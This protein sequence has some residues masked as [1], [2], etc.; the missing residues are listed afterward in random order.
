MIIMKHMKTFKM[1][2]RKTFKIKKLDEKLTLL[3]TANTNMS[4]AKVGN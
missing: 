3:I 4:K 2:T 1:N